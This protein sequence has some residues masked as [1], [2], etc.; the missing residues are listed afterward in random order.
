[1]SDV[2]A[3]ARP[4]VIVANPVVV[5]FLLPESLA[6]ATEYLIGLSACVPLAAA[7]N[8]AQGVIRHGPENEMDVVGHDDPLVEQVLL[9]VKVQ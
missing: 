1:M 2:P 3:N 5:G 7:Q 4:F 6:G 9:F 8:I